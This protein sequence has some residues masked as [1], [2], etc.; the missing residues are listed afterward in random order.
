MA[1]IWPNSLP[2]YILSDSK[3]SAEINVFN[4]LA[5]CLDESWTVY[6]SR[7]WWGLNPRG[8]E[9]DGEADFIVAHP[10]E[11][12]LFLEV[13]GGQISYQP[14]TEQWTSTDR[15]GI[16]HKIKDPVLQ[17]SSCKHQYLRKFRK[18]SGWPR[19]FVRVRHGIVFP[20]T[21]SPLDDVLF[22]ATYEVFLFCFSG[23]FDSDFKSWILSR[24]K[25]HETRSGELSTE[26][27]PG[28]NGIDCIDQILARPVTL[29]PS[30]LRE[31]RADER[32]LDM[33][34]TNLQLSILSILE[35]SPAFIVEGGA[36]TGKTILAREIAVRESSP[37]GMSLFLCKS[38]A[39]V[40]YLEQTTN[41]PNVCVLTFESFLKKFGKDTAFD[42]LKITSVI[43]DEAQDFEED[44][45]DIVR[46]FIDLRDC[47]LRIFGDSN[48]SVYRLKARLDSHFALQTYPLSA[49]LRNTKNIAA[50]TN[51]YYKGPKVHRIGPDGEVP[52]RKQVGNLQAVRS[53]INFFLSLASS[54]PAVVG[55]VS[56]LTLTES[57]ASIVGSELNNSGYKTQPAGY[58][59]KGNLI[60]DTI[61][62]FKGLESDIVLLIFE[63]NATLSEE[64][65]YVGLSRAKSLLFVFGDLQERLLQPLSIQD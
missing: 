36:G 1:R 22:L 2:G 14:D 30:V 23:E 63:D 9:I 8:A 17:A 64:L 26:I 65:I 59:R 55:L 27:G 4:K 20:D 15:M 45:W 51:Y 61:S 34:A 7:P 44:W 37:D 24:F 58:R 40:D 39:L 10:E 5:I 32:A 43:V 13:K 16:T 3:R 56:I 50:L 47:K 38:A 46:E 62:N 29:M 28:E 33:L 60:I 11:G 49:N 52:L 41:L 42:S 31:V 48:Q 18:M 54:E 57:G 35:D 53:A 19:D 6:Y 21:V 25:R 12:I